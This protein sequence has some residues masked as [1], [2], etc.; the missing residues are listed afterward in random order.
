MKPAGPL[1]LGRRY[2]A[3]TA[4]TAPLRSRLGIAELG[5]RLP[6]YERIQ[7]VEGLVLCRDMNRHSRASRVHGLKQRLRQ[8]LVE[9]K[10][11]LRDMNE[12]NRQL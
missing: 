5:Q 11:V 10:L 3:L 7:A 12:N 2:S 9:F 1:K 8:R 4:R 6:A